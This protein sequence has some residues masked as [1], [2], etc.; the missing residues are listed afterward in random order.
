MSAGVI[1]PQIETEWIQKESQVARCNAYM[2]GIFRLVVW[3]KVGKE[4]ND[5]R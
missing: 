5:K 4:N 3:S 1:V 2:Q